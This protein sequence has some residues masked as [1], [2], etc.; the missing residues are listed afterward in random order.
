[1]CWLCWNEIEPEHKY[2]YDCDTHC[3]ECGELTNPNA[4]H[5]VKHSAANLPTECGGMGT[6]EYWYCEVCGCVW[7]NEELTQIGNRFNVIV[8]KDHELT[9]VAAKDATEAADGNIE[10]WYCADCDTYFA[11]EDGSEE[12]DKADTIITYVPPTGDA[13]ALIPALILALLSVTG[14]ALLIGKKRLL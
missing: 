2:N 1:M 7:T 5:T 6:L 8:F 9:H 13:S 11:D 14:T 12:I 10:Y 3:S 4:Q